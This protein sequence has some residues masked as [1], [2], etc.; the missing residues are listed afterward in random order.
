MPRLA[1]YCHGL[2]A[3]LSLV[4]LVSGCVRLPGP[5]TGISELHDQVEKQLLR[6]AT[7]AFVQADYAD[8]IAL[9]R[10]FVGTHPHSSRTLEARW[11]LARSYQGS[12]DLPSAAE[13][14]RVLANAP[15]P[16]P[17][18]A[19]A[20]VRA[21]RLE[22]LLGKPATGEPVNGILVSLTSPHLSDDRVPVLADHH[23]IEGSVILLDIPCGH[24]RKGLR[25]GQP[26]LPRAM[27]S[28]VRQLHG[29]GAAVY[30]GVTL[31][32]LG[33]M[34]D[35]PHRTLAQWRDWEYVPSS[36]SRSATTS[37]ALRRSP[38][39]SLGNTGYLEFLVGWLSQLRGLPLTGLVLRSEV[40][41]G[42]DEGFSPLALAAFK[43]EFDVHF[44][45]VQ[46]LDEYGPRSEAW[47]DA[48]VQLPAVFWK[49]AGWKAR[50]RLRTLRYLVDTLR[51][52]LPHL[53][54]G[55]EVQYHS[56][57]DPAYGLVHLA[58]DWVAI[59]RSP[60]DVF[61]TTIDDTS[62]ALP[63]AASQG[64]PAQPDRS[65]ESME[66]GAYPVFD[67]V[68]YLGKPDKVWAIV[69]SQTPQASGQSWRLPEGVGRV[70]D[71]RVVP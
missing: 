26:L 64:M 2:V 31:R 44:D 19:E 56:V 34:A 38:Y 17:Y 1:L 37:G 12:G 68:R 23:P 63:Y 46:I 3:A 70:R 51:V 20:R 4:L 66:E 33:N 67:M 5:D 24:D 45:P 13:H 29:R 54:V 43:R 35:V 39:Y 65:A 50:E 52:R 8:A 10:R 60:F 14:F 32:C 42:I 61:L 9:L 16:N 27:D 59:A 48:S 25:N 36:R 57:A 11:W 47:P 55:L 49:W 21:T 41:S 6:D 22:E 18:R 69:S 53:Q 58:E 7:L 62:P 28:V 15:M 71:Y 40:P 30:L